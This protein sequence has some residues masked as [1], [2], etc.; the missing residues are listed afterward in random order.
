MIGPIDDGSPA[1]SWRAA[2]APN[3]ACKGCGHTVCDHPDA[4]YQ[5]VVPLRSPDG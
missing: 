3:A 5:G 1:G 4:V 2:L